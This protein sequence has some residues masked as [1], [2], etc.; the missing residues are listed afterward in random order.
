MALSGMP[1]LAYASESKKMLLIGVFVDE[2]EEDDEEDEVSPRERSWRHCTTTSLY[3]LNKK[4]FTASSRLVLPVPQWDVSV[5][6]FALLKSPCRMHATNAG[7][8]PNVC[9]SYSRGKTS[10]ADK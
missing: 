9:R 6:V 8:L 3:F 10:K 7:I 1:L 4:S 5:K 2:E